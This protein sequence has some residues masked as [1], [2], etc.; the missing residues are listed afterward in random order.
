[1]FNLSL[2]VLQGNLLVRNFS[3]ETVVG[4]ATSSTALV[5][6]SSHMVIGTY[7]VSVFVEYDPVIPANANPGSPID[8]D[9]T[10]WL[11]HD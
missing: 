4:I 8:S 11:C 2:R 6:K 10:C 7:A 5:I 9:G 3:D 1:M